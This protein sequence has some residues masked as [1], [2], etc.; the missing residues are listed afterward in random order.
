LI[1]HTASTDDIID[2]DI[3]VLHPRA[4]G[5]LNHIFVTAV[6][7]HLIRA[8]QLTEVEARN[9]LPESIVHWGKISFLKGGDKIRA[10]ELVQHSEHNMTRDASFIKVQFP[11][12]DSPLY[13]SYLL[14]LSFCRQK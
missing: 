7:N 5:P 2:P 13:L 14:V 3:R 9:C 1:L 6:R 8:Y 4:E 11:S 10:S 12:S